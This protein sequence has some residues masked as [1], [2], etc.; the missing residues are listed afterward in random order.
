M[1]ALMYRQIG[2]VSGFAIVI[3][4]M[5]GLVGRFVVSVALSL[6]PMHRRECFVNQGMYSYS[7]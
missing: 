5:L 3:S 7:N 6:T 2:F 4:L 1:P